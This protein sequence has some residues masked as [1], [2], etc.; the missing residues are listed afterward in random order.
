MLVGGAFLVPADFHF[1]LREPQR[2]C[3]LLH[4]SPVLAPDK[5]S[6]LE[7]DS[8][9]PRFLQQ[10]PDI[11]RPVDTAVGTTVT[12]Q[13]N[14]DGHW[15]AVAFVEDSQRLGMSQ[16]HKE[17]VVKCRPVFDQSL[18]IP[19]LLEVSWRKL[20]S[21][22]GGTGWCVRGKG[23]LLTPK[24]QTLWSGWKAALCWQ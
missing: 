19:S 7:A 17:V 24:A 18:A 22:K 15:G 6:D 10:R 5:P 2:L 4:C 14:G 3:K 12:K 23:M 8:P 21:R 16:R 1:L 20:G 11:T 13:G 9:G